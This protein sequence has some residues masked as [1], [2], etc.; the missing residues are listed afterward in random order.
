VIV[1][2]WLDRLAVARPTNPA[3]RAIL[4]SVTRIAALLAFAL[5]IYV[6]AYRPAS[7]SDSYVD[8]VSL[9]TNTIRAANDGHPFAAYSQRDPTRLIRI[10]EFASGYYDPGLPALIS[11]TSLIGRAAFGA[12]F[13]V[14]RR[15]I[16][17]IVFGL[18]VLAGLV[19]IC[20]TLPLPVSLGGL[21]A[22]AASIL[23]PVGGQ[24]A[25]TLPRWWE[26]Y[27]TI[28]VGMLVVGL[29]TGR[30]SRWRPLYFVG[31]T[32]L[33]S[34]SR[35]LREEVVVTTYAALGGLVATLLTLWLVPRW[36]VKSP[37]A[38][39]AIWRPLRQSVLVGTSFCLGLAVGPYLLRGAIA[40]AANSV[41]PDQHRRSRHRAFAVPRPRRRAE[42][43]RHQWARPSGDV[44]QPSHRPDAPRGG[45]AL[46]GRSAAR[47]HSDHA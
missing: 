12:Q 4:G 15:T 24:H 6:V 47:S 31:L 33:A 22:L 3:R 32:I 5:V 44:S 26:A 10:D 39:E 21:A 20:P 2:H 1:S 25:F 41:R 46:S 11:V 45:S 43:V 23:I 35:L 8:V 29:L 42:P 30:R 13:K 9:L 16:Y 14:D 36:W 7:R 40:V 17:Q 27:S 18:C 34:F 28:L 37:S 19:V 38:A